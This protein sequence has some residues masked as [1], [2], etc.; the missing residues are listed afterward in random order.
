MKRIAIILTVFNRKNTTLLGLRQ[1]HKVIEN[2]NDIDVSIFMT[3]DGCTDG[4]AKAV[5]EEFP[6]IHIIQGDGNLYWSGGMRKAWGT[7]I[8]TGKY[9]YYL[10]YNDDAVLYDNALNIMLKASAEEGDF[11][12]VSGAFQNEQSGNTSYGG[13]T[14]DFRLVPLNP[15]RNEEV[16]F[17]NGN[18]VLIPQ[19]V[20][21]I[22]GNIDKHYKHSLGDWDYSARGYQQGIRTV[23]TKMYV[24]TTSRHDGNGISSAY[25]KNISFID[26]L[27]KL[28]SPFNHPSCTWH[29]KRAHFGYLS[30]IA[31]IVKCHLLILFPQLEFWSKKEIY[32]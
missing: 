3:D 30:A 15:L 8:E 1:L 5:E 21:N 32:N 22:L 25:D 16:F 11:T 14:K 20:F 6:Q 19:N 23:I 29:F 18:F 31:A 10:W 13:W 9:D 4:T 2:T 27:K 7:A 26:R 24:G 28:Y 12:I 17:M